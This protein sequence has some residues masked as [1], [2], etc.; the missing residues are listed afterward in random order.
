MAKRKRLTPRLS[1]AGL[2]T[3]RERL[4]GI[5]KWSVEAGESDLRIIWKRPPDLAAE[6]VELRLEFQIESDAG[7]FDPDE[8]MFELWESIRKRR[9]T[10]LRDLRRKLGS[11]VLGDGDGDDDLERPDLDPYDPILIIRRSE[12]GGEARYGVEV[13]AEAGDDEHV[14]SLPYHIDRGKFGRH[15]ELT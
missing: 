9:T 4:D 7:G 6:G 13:V 15:W 3:I 8:R 12:F 1:E 2:A 10:L 5:G 14:L 11:P